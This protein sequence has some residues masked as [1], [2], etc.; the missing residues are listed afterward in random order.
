MKEV[1]EMIASL[2]HSLLHFS[3]HS[4]DSLNQFQLHENISDHMPEEILSLYGLACGL[5][6]EHRMPGQEEFRSIDWEKIVRG[7]Q[8]SRL[9]V[10]VVDRRPTVIA[11]PDLVSRLV[12]Y[13]PITIT[14]PVCINQH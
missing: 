14:S 13:L 6:C 4:A 7:F 9:S 2:L 1:K 8:G 11:V 12:K 5:A 10:Q 3:D